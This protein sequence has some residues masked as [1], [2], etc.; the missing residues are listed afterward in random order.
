M[1]ISGKRLIRTLVFTYIG[2][3]YLFLGVMWFAMLAMLALGLWES[4]LLAD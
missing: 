3:L 1:L 4:D 2:S